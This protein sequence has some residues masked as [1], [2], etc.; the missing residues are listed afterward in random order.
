MSLR[1]ASATT[2]R[3]QRV[4]RRRLI[5]VLAKQTPSDDIPWILRTLEWAKG[6]ADAVADRV[7]KALDGPKGREAR[8]AEAG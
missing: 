1:L 4:G 5:P 3:F 8:A 7:L 2:L 6:S